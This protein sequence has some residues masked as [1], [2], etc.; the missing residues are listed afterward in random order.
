MTGSDGK[1]VTLTRVFNAPREL[2]FKAFTDLDLIAQWWGPLGFDVPALDVDAR[3]GGVMNIDMRGPDG[4]IYAGQG[5]F[6]EVNAPERL[7]FL[8][9]DYFDETG[10]PQLEVLHTVTFE[11]QG[12]QT[13]LTLRC[14][15]IRSTPAVAEALAGMEPGWN[16]GFDKLAQFLAGMVPAQ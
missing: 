7:V 1:I 8:A 3:P 9:A 5:S 12:S 14:E 13:R 10:T 15:V 11:A 2:V 4:V 6:R 16:E